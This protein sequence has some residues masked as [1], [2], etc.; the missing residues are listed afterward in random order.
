MAATPSNQHQT[1]CT[2]CRLDSEQRQAINERLLDGES[3]TAMALEIG[4]DRTSVH[5]HLRWLM[6]QMRDATPATI[7]AALDHLSTLVETSMGELARWNALPDE[8]RSP[9]D[10]ERLTRAALAPLKVELGRLG[11]ATD[12]ASLEIDGKVDVRVTAE[13]MA[14]AQ[15]IHDAVRPFPEARQAIEQALTTT[16]LEVVR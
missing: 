4:I 16:K 7:R 12:K 9:A 5:R 8:E 3:R 2:I 13:A 14:V 15:Q 6:T 1:Q 10:L 11:V